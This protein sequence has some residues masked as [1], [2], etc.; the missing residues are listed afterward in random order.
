[1]DGWPSIKYWF[2]SG[3]GGG[4]GGGGASVIFVSTA[5]IHHDLILPRKTVLVFLS[6]L[7]LPYCKFQI[8]HFSTKKENF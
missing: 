8:S 2:D 7:G 6:T 1:M 5:I 4:G 3:G